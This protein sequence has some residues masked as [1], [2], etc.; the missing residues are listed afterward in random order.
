MAWDKELIRQLKVQ[1]KVESG[2][3]N[4][5]E[6]IKMELFYLHTTLLNMLNDEKYKEAHAEALPFLKEFQTKSNSSQLNEVEVC[7]NAIYMNLLMRLKK[8]EITN[9]TELA[10]DK[11][12]KLIKLLT[13]SF[14]KM[15][16]GD[17][18]YINN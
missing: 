8:Q 5:L 14:H 12:K 18:N 4:D 2:H 7:L 6:E 17:L 10:F 3:L 9:E 15:K 13:T 1:G 16:R 11:F